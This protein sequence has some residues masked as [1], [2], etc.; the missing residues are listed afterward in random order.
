MPKAM[1]ILS[2]SLAAVWTYRS[3]SLFGGEAVLTVDSVGGRVAFTTVT[4]EQD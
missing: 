3:R 4:Q 2:P 1:R